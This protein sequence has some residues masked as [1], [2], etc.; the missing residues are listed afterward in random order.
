MCEENLRCGEADLTCQSEKDD[1][2][3]GNTMSTAPAAPN[4]TIL[5]L[6]L[7]QGGVGLLRRRE[8]ASKTS[9]VST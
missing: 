5:R 6:S 4:H 9:H 1:G 8:E 7:N 2:K 3:W